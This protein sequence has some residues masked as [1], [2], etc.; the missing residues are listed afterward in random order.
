MDVDD[1]PDTGQEKQGSS[2]TTPATRDASNAFINPVGPQEKAKSSA[3]PSTPLVFDK[4][5][6]SQGL[7][8][9]P[10]IQASDLGNFSKKRSRLETPGTTAE[11]QA[12]ELTGTPRSNRIQDLFPGANEPKSLKEMVGE[13]L[14]VIKAGFPLANKS[15]TTK[16]ITVDVESAADILVL[17]G[18]VY[19]R[20]LYEDAR[21]KFTTPEALSGQPQKR[22]II[23]KGR[24]T[25]DKLDTIVE[26][27]A[28][29]S[30]A[31][32]QKNIPVPS[33]KTPTTSYALAAS[34][35][36]PNNNHQTN[37]VP[38]KPKAPTPKH[39]SK[40]KPTNVITL[41]HTIGAEITHPNLSNAK[42]IQELNLAFR[43]YNVKMKPDDKD[44]IE[45]KSVRRHPS[46]DIDIYFETSAQ[47]A[48]RDS[49]KP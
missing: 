14:E 37:T 8:Q 47:A 5:K 44:A 24:E 20:V 10:S 29:L 30:N 12:A 21:R 48:K 45:I 41:S 39:P 6:F 42:L 31:I 13:L 28:I 3:N 43:A 49:Q 40:I 16:K 33:K 18:A 22:S 4:E 7:N 17:T 27:L 25:E 15:K 9:T 46:N 35:H 19:D 34:K 11:Y 1:A 36:A 38:N 26:Q 32:G 23:F 2:K